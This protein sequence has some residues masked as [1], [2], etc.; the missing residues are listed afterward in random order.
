MC[1]RTRLRRVGFV[2]DEAAHWD[3]FP[4]TISVSPANSQFTNCAT[5]TGHAKR[6]DTDSV[7][8]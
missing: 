1:G 8:K 3:D 2:V 5:I 4:P 7:V 6:L